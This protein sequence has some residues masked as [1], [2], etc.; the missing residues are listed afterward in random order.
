MFKLLS[1]EKKRNLVMPKHLTK[2]EK[3]EIRQI[4]KNAQKNHSSLEYL[5][6]V[7]GMTRLSG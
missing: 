6:L 5:I 7:A 4:M 3:K 2:A 1:K